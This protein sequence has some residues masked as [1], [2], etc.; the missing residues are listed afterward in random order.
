M[1]RSAD[2]L[3]R[4]LWGRV[5]G[6]VG[7]LLL[8]PLAVLTG[9]SSAP[10]T[11]TTEP[12][13]DVPIHLDENGFNDHTVPEVGSRAEY[14]AMAR[15]VTAGRSVLKFSIQQMLVGEA[16]H[17]LDSNFYELHDEWCIYRL[18]NGQP[19]PGSSV[20]P[21]D[22]Q[23]FESIDAIYDWALPM[24]ESSLPVGLRFADSQVLRDRRLYAPNF[25]DLARNSP[26][27]NYG[28]GS[29]VHFP[30]TEGQAECWVIELEFTDDVTVDEVALFFERLTPTLP[31]DI[32]EMLEWVVRSPD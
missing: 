22:G 13:V 19:V 3:R 31:T 17:W 9:C 27:R 32:G 21:I 30:A 1:A 23:S 16:V 12:L 14:F 20:S 18:L 15:E 29:V 10:T 6:N 8:G 7:R 2:E 28:L 11:T 24:R 5:R 26:E 4:M 25:Y